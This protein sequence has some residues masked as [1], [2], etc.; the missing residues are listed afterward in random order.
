MSFNYSK[1]A[2]LK[3]NFLKEEE[4]NDKE[5]NKEASSQGKQPDKVETK[6]AQKDDQVDLNANLKTDQ[7]QKLSDD[8][9]RNQ[10]ST[11]L[12]VGLAQNELSSVS[13]DHNE[14]SSKRAKTKMNLA[15]N[16]PSLTRTLLDFNQS[17]NYRS[18]NWLDD[19]LMPKLEASEQIVLRRLFRLSYGFNRQH[20]DNVSLSKLAEKCNL[21][22]ATIKRAITSLEMKGMIEVDS[23]LTRNP[24]G[25]NRYKVLTRFIMSLAHSE[26]SSNRSKLTMSHIKDDDD[27]DDLKRQDHHL[28]RNA[29]PTNLSEHEKTVMMIY[30]NIT[31]N[32]WTK[33]DSD[34]YIKVKSIP[35]E[36]IEIALR[37]ASERAK[38]RPNSFAF[39]IKEILSVSS[40]K[41]QSR[42]QQKKAME[43]IMID[44]RNSKVGSSNYTIS[45]F[46][47]DVKEVCI[48]E[49]V[50]FD[51]NIFDELL[52]KK[53]G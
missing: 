38:N 10:P 37:L 50:T 23:D 42:S 4:Q 47:Y 40:P 18:L 11:K 27:H 20:T 22:L 12:N 15:Q 28:T 53:K 49:D 30:Q 41:K 31:E 13:L 39:F 35:V 3:P 33:A 51:N 43:K 6:V 17:P 1:L 2:T 8:Q 44:I 34:A 32:V 16:E 48:R 45:D 19:E 21:G 14:L 25:G 36:K 24:N 7:D 46:A 5:S 29:Q 52:E 26:L 9:V